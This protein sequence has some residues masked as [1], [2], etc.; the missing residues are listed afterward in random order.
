M[1]V[2][3]I[4]LLEQ[5][6]LF[7]QLSVLLHLLLDNFAFGSLAHLV[8]QLSA[9]QVFRL[10]PTQKLVLSDVVEVVTRPHVEHFLARDGRPLWP[11]RLA[12]LLVWAGPAAALQH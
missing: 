3:F 6:K 8:L 1:L 4:D 12:S 7:P 10:F 11:R 9:I 5:F 2:D